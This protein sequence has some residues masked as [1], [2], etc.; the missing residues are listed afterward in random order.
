VRAVLADT[1]PL[2][3][4]VDP[5]DQHHRRAHAE[6]K[7]LR[8]ERL[9]LMTSWSNVTE[10]YNLVLQGLSIPKA[11]SWLGELTPRISLFNPSDEDYFEAVRRLRRYSDQ[12]ISLVD[13]VLAVL[14]DQLQIPVWT[15]DHHFD[16]MRTRVWR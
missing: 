2:Y 14:S 13:A 12:D 10:A 7:R 6:L 11:Q 5:D 8:K 4:L 9:P 3:A 15:F 16:V 1:G